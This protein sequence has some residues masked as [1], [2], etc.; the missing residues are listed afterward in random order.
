MP[1]LR[2]AITPA[3]AEL[4]AEGYQLALN[5][6]PNLIAIEV[7]AEDGMNVQSYTA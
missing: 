4:T 1:V 2:F 3:D 5:V 6:G 7:T